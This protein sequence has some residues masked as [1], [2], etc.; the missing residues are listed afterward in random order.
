MPVRPWI[1]ATGR[2][3]TPVRPW[4]LA[5]GRPA[6]PVRPDTAWILNSRL[7]RPAVSTVGTTALDTEPDCFFAQVVV[8]ISSYPAVSSIGSAN[9]W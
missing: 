4:I 7:S 8:T 2:P 1:L 6:T 3:A 5:T 9:W